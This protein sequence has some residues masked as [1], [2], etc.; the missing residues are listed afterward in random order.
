MS[1]RNYDPEFREIL[2]LL[3]TVTDFSSLEEIQHLPY[4]IDLAEVGV[5]SPRLPEGVLCLRASCLLAAQRQTE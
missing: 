4:A 1:E 2:P 5:S 3:P